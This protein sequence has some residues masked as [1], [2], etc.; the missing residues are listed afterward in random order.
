MSNYSPLTLLVS[1]ASFP[2]SSKEGLSCKQNGIQNK[3][4]PT[5]E[6][7]TIQNT[8]IYILQT[9]GSIQEI[10]KRHHDIYMSR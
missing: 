4:H 2:D 9:E 10:S 5:N 1:A 3:I 6:Q 8:Y 7:Q